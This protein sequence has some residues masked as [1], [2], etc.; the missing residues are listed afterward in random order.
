MQI[1][2]L[3]Y[4][5]SIIN[6]KSLFN[7][8]SHSVASIQGLTISNITCKNISPLYKIIVDQSQ[9]SQCFLKTTG[10]NSSGS[11]IMANLNFHNNIIH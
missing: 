5:D 4:S 6:S 8:F 1:S 2:N 11:F 3:S 9:S 10:M 7:F